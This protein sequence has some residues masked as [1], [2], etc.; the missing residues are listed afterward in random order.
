LGGFVVVAHGV[1]EAK[2][3]VTVRFIASKTEWRTVT[4][5]VVTDWENRQQIKTLSLR[6]DSSLDLLNNEFLTWCDDKHPPIQV[7]PSPPYTKEFN[8]LA[9]RTIG[10]LKRITRSFLVHA[11]LPLV[12]FSYALNQAMHMRNNLIHPYKNNI[13]YEQWFKQPTHVTKFKPFGCLVSIYIFKEQRKSQNSVSELGV[14]LGNK[15]E[16][17]YFCYNYRTKS[18]MTYYHVRFYPDIFPGLSSPK[19]NPPS[20]PMRRKRM[21]SEEV[22]D[23]YEPQNTYNNNDFM[24]DSPSLIH[25]REVS[26]PTNSDRETSGP[27]TPE[28]E[29]SGPSNSE[30][31]LESDEEEQIPRRSSR[32]RQVPREYWVQHGF[33]QQN[34]LFELT[35]ANI[36]CDIQTLT[37]NDNLMKVKI[38]SVSEKQKLTFNPVRPQNDKIKWPEPAPSAFPKDV[39][40]SI[41]SSELPPIPKNVQEAVQHDKYGPFFLA[42]MISEIESFNERDIYTMIPRPS[43]KEHILGSK[44]VFAYKLDKDNNLIRFKARCVAQGFT[45]IPGLNYNE[46]F[47]PVVKIESIRMAV[48]MSLFYNMEMEQMDV[49]T[50][51]LYGTLKEKNLMRIPLGF[52]QYD[53][54]GLPYVL[55]LKHSLYGLHQGSRE[56]YL[57]L[58][59]TATTEGFIPMKSDPC[60]LLK[61]DKNRHKMLILL[62][63]IDDLIFVTNSEELM[64][65]MKD[66][67]KIYYK[68]QDIGTA[69]WILKIQIERVSNGI[70]L[71]QPQYTQKILEHVNFWN[72]PEKE[73]KEVPMVATWKNDVNSPLLSDKEK[74]TYI[75]VKVRP[76]VII[77]S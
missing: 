53:K 77:K 60:V 3:N 62:V 35:T 45:Q 32:N 11:H 72:I 61:Y 74:F 26:R 41:K 20:S 8:G 30:P 27:S 66:S 16:N 56:W 44:W 23:E 67:I 57:E 5:S 31:V 29:I 64:K 22:E 68:T 13:P 47:S 24:E 43:H 7:E 34:K 18:V 15:G 25:D 4:Q 37:S 48:A 55:D 49:S 50:A 33:I 14:F 21:R 70:Y 54:A 73:F 12:M 52:E 10:I 63:Y 46:T 59:K 65:K 39:G 1:A 36:Q 9:E 69:N 17:L 28:P 40:L 42:A 71:G 58:K 38:N 51:F 6:S 2:P 76:I 75:S 19:P